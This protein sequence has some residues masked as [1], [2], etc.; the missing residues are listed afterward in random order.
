[1]ENSYAHFSNRVT[2]IVFIHKER[3]IELFPRSIF[4]KK[5]LPKIN[6][7]DARKYTVKLSC[8]GQ[9]EWNNHRPCSSKWR[10]VSSC[11]LF[12]SDHSPQLHEFFTR[13]PRLIIPYGFLLSSLS[14][15]IDRLVDAHT[16]THTYTRGVV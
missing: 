1:M 11:P 5:I 6:D 14:I 7:F 8:Y 16:H 13:Q 9:K 3:A 4:E 12:F 15:L 10:R 2:R